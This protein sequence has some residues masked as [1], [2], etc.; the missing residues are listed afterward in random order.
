MCKICEYLF[1][2]IY[3]IKFKEKL[4]LTTTMFTIKI[5]H[6]T[7]ILSQNRREKGKSTP[8]ANK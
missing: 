4:L 2:N 6:S 5:S 1:M 3:S 7:K 8:L